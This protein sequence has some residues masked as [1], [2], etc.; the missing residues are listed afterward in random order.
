MVPVYNEEAVLEPAMGLLMDA[1]GRQLNGQNW[2]IVIASNGC[3]D[4]TNEIARRLEADAGGRIKLIVCEQRGRGRALREV[5]AQVDARSYLYI[6][7]DLPCE[8]DDL[9]KVLAPLAQGADVVAS[10]RMGDR[11]PVRRLMTLSL[12]WLNRL[13]FGVRVSD[14]QCAVKAFS[15]RGAEVLVRD[16]QQNGWYLDTELVVLSR[17]RG[18]KLA[19]VPIHW[20]ETRFAG[21]D[22]KVDVVGDS[23]RAL[24]SLRQIWLRRREV[25]S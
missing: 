4:A 5:F 7:V 11:P 19:E 14:S 8:L 24:R 17:A 9:P 25:N 1:L 18:L 13:A 15:P 16:C 23:L 21:R 10:H 6:D 22:S 2:V 20:L 12:R 3:T